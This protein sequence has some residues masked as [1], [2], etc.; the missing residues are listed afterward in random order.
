MDTVWRKECICNVVCCL[1]PGTNPRHKE[2]SYNLMI[3]TA[4]A[5]DETTGEVFVDNITIH[6]D[7]N[8]Y[9][10]PNIA[11]LEDETKFKEDGY[12]GI[13]KLVGEILSPSS[14]IRDRVEKLKLYEKFGVPE[15]WIVEPS[16]GYIEQYLL[17]NGKYELK[18][19]CSVLSDGE[20]KRLNKEEKEEYTTV[21]KPCCYENIEIDIKEVF[22]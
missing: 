2:I 6:F 15:Y 1:S 21:I 11:I 7:E 18:K 20:Y 16:G 3:K 12:Y 17:E 8:N 19:I 10:M 4:D 9:V 22:E 5:L 14:I 13:P